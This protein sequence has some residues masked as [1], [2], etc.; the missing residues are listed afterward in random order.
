MMKHTF[1]AV[2]LM[3]L[4]LFLAACEPLQQAGQSIGLSEKPVAAQPATVTIL[5]T[6][7]FHSQF[8]PL[9]PPEEPSQGGAARLKALID[10][11]R[12]EKGEK[13]VLLLNAGDNFQ[14]TM[15][16]NTW[17]GSAEVMMLNH[18]RFDA[19]TLGN[20][21]FDSGPEQL[22][23][24]LRGEPVTIAGEAYPTEAARFITVASN[25]DASAVP[26]LAE[27][28]VKRA[29]IHKGGNSYGIIGVTTE[30]TAN[31]SSPGEVR[32]LDYLTS[33]QE[34]VA[35]LEAEG[36][37]KI[38]LLS[39]SG[40]DEDMKRVPML[41]GVDVIIAGHDHALF[42]D[43]LSIAAMGLPQQA[44][45]VV[46][47][48]PTLRKDKDGH[49]VLI[50]SAMEKGRWLGNI[51]VTFDADGL[52]QDGAWQANPI[53]V[54]GCIYEKDVD[55][56]AKMPDCSKQAAE[57]DVHFTKVLDTYRK[58]MEAVANQYLGV[59]SV[60][61]AGRHAAG[62]DV[63]SMGNLTADIILD[64]TREGFDTDGA[65]VNR[66]GMRA[67]L[68]KGE[69]RYK[70]I[71]TVLPF[72]NTVAVV[73]LTGAQLLEAMDVAVSEAGGKSYGA[74]PHVS[75]MSI[76]YCGEPVCEGAL[77]QGGRIVDLEVQ[78]QD[79][80][81]AQRYRIATNDYLAKGG[82]FYTVFQQACAAPDNGCADTG[83]LLRDVVAEWFRSH[84]P[85]GAVS[86]ERVV[87]VP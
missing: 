64:Y 35:A 81:L 55:G 9:Q 37:N 52:I 45:R 71:N 50:V 11:I 72:D 63:H 31:V 28:L 10:S 62:A 19:V 59:A 58:P 87:E 32:F 15:F 78:G 20:H 13:N 29:I 8:D 27:K 67:D 42:G 65:V 77:L 25:T 38:I 41:S 49:N 70:D 57:P 1:Y 43:K 80:D 79:I 5:H 46:S 86:Q 60:D 6:N 69:V 14:G 44:E 12:M 47:E 22:A 33:V 34:Q 7:D 75:G 68:P 39:H 56:N 53:F 54:H 40:S 84:T 3:A 85:V 76:R 2:G 21:E 23:S 30:T 24:A 66:G 26:Q 17:K 36:I 73:E 74:Y 51:D 82:D 61:F 18:L 48:Y 83:T 16:Y 4:V